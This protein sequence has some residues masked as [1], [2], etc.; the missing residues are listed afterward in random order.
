MKKALP[1]II[2]L[3]MLA[4]LNWA[5]VKNEGILKDGETLYVELAPVDPRSLM[6][7]DYMALAFAMEREVDKEKLK[8]RSKT[9]RL[10]IE[11][12]ENQVARF[13]EFYNDQPLKPGQR[14]IRYNK[15]TRWNRPV[16]IQPSTYFFQEGHRK[17]YQRAKYGVYK[18]KGPHTYLL[19]D[20]A[21]ETFTI[22]S[23]PNNDKADQ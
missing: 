14:T 2:G 4:G 12:D 16:A 7:G 21:D 19:T 15:S 18:Y 22:I 5:I 3:L 17:Y 13:I 11:T 23:P 6:Q 8:N 9:G 10:I 20:L 1:L